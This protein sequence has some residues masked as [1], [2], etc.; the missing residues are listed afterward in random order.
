MRQL[1]QVQETKWSKKSKIPLGQHQ[2]EVLHQAEEDHLAE[3]LLEVE[4]PEVVLL[5]S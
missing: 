5:D 4:W 2:G 3:V 1:L